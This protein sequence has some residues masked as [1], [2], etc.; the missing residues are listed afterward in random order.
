MRRTGTLRN[1]ARGGKGGAKCRGSRNQ[2]INL[3]GGNTSRGGRKGWQFGRSICETGHVRLPCSKP[4]DVADAKGSTGGK[5]YKKEARA[6]GYSAP[7][8]NSCFWEMAG[9]KVGR[10]GG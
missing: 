9:N 3:S 8:P 4:E 7:K 6:A 10:E 5:D 1:P 2:G